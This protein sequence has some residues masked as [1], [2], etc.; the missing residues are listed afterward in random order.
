VAD[1]LLGV[2]VGDQRIKWLVVV[3][4]AAILVAVI[5]C[6]N[7]APPAG[8]G[9][10]ATAAA[11]QGHPAHRPAPV[12]GTPAV[13]NTSKIAAKTAVKKSRSRWNF[14]AAEDE[15]ELTLRFNPFAPKP[16][17]QPQLSNGDTPVTDP[18]LLRAE[19]ERAERARALAAQQRLT[20]FRAQKVKVFLRTADGGS[21]ALIG[22]R[23]VRE[24]DIVDGVRV[25]S[26]SA[27]AVVLEAAP[28]TSE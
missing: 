14:A 27:D 28:T 16:A 11:R 3:A 5:V 18:N 12:S 15:L 4:L 10:T 26:I 2:S 19:E 22:G 21:V 9:A 1:K 23:F 20:K 25:L 8:A 13:E 6:G 24:G 17:L 7:D